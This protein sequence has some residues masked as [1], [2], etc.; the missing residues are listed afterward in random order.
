MHHGRRPITTENFIQ[1]RPIANIA[2]LQRPP[3]HSPL[4]PILEIVVGDRSVPSNRQ[5]L[6]SVAANVAGTA[7]DENVRHQLA[8]PMRLSLQARRL[9]AVDYRSMLSFS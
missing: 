1:A 6:T 2:T 9:H 7:G 8:A 5:C 3:F 4:V